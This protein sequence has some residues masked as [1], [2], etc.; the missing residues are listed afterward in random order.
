M[1]WKNN[2]KKWP[3]VDSCSEVQNFIDQ[4]C[5]VYEVP[6]IKVIIKSK[7]WIEWFAGK[8]VSACAFWPNEGEEDAKNAQDLND[9]Y[10]RL[11]G[12]RREPNPVPKA[13]GIA[14]GRGRGIHRTLPHWTTSLPYDP[15]FPLS[16]QQRPVIPMGRQLPGP[17]IPTEA[18]TRPLMIGNTASQREAQP[19][20]GINAALGS[21]YTTSAQQHNTINF[22]HLGRQG[23]EPP[24]GGDGSEEVRTLSKNL[25]TQRCRYCRV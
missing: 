13:G 15:N 9:N 14:S 3:K 12:F 19:S 24:K 8:G 7:K 2:F 16:M 5:L 23:S 17:A 11:E 6:P 4:M 20:E 25:M 1:F 10:E 22:V 21:A 18:A